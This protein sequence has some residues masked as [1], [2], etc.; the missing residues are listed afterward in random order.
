MR[1][2]VRKLERLYWKMVRRIFYKDWPI[3]LA[4]TDIVEGQEQ[5]EPPTGRRVLAEFDLNGRHYV[6][7]AK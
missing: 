1:Y 7:L 2:F 6:V 5:Y 3:D 4:Y